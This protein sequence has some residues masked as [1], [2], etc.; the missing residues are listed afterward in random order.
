[1]W[2]TQVNCSGSHGQRE[3]KSQLDSAEDEKTAPKYPDP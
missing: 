3:K 2:F 1:M